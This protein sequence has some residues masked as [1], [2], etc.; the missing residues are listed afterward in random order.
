MDLLNSHF[1]QLLSGV[2]Y[3]SVT[4]SDQWKKNMERC[5]VG[6]LYHSLKHGWIN[7]YNMVPEYKEEL[8][9]MS[10]CLGKQNVM[11]VLDDVEQYN[12]NET[13]RILS[14]NP[15]VTG[16]SSLLL[17]IPKDK[18]QKTFEDHRTSVSEF[19]RRGLLEGTSAS[20]PGNSDAC[21]KQANPFDVSVIEQFSRKNP[22]LD[23]PSGQTHS[24]RVFSRCAKS[25]YNWLVNLLRSEEFGS[26]VKEVQGVEIS[27]DF[28]QFLSDIN[29]CTF[30]ILYHSLNYGRVNITN[31]PDSLYDQHLETLCRHH[32]KEKVIVVIDDLKDSS[33]QK[34]NCILHEQP[35]IGRYSKEL[36]LFSETETKMGSNTSHTIRNKLEMLKKTLKTSSGGSGHFDQFPPNRVGPVASSSLV[37][38]ASF[39]SPVSSDLISGEAPIIVFGQSLDEIFKHMPREAVYIKQLFEEVKKEHTME[40]ARLKKKHDAEIADLNHQLE[41]SEK[42]YYMEISRQNQLVEDQV[43]LYSQHKNRDSDARKKQ[44]YAVV[45]K[46]THLWK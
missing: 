45:S 36:L 43:K 30:A 25:T 39:S 40:I 8:N 42:K 26:L 18:K 1:S 3:L 13:K 6:I 46:N 19:L 31:V 28:S 20:S 38:T 33:S 29:H 11:V 23:F 41:E 24:V 9:H 34:K 15:T 37:P 4:N 16:C 35:S 2:Q 12:M 21:Y 10:S 32:G 7:K 17:L 14:A 5:S 27:N 22:K 44:K